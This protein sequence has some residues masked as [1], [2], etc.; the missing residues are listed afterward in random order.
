MNRPRLCRFLPLVLL[1]CVPAGE[2]QAMK[3]GRSE[4]LYPLQDV[5]GSRYVLCHKVSTQ[6]FIA[7]IYVTD[8]GYVLKDALNFMPTERYIPLDP[9][10]IEDLQR[11]G[12]LPSPLPKY[13]IPFWDYFFGYSL[14]GL[15][16][17]MVG[18]PLLSRLWRR[19]ETSEESPPAG[20]KLRCSACNVEPS[21]RETESGV[22]DL[23][24]RPLT[25]D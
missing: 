15:L 3:F 9:E 21:P 10:K 23:C 13:S 4:T 16:A 1:S 19:S 22:C 24:G 25:A 7:G 8:D 2:A 11:E 12:V 14:W 6:W 17:L 20:K 5:E 18:L